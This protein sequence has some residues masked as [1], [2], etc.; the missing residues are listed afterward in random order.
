MEEVHKV[1]HR[2]Y[3]TGFFFGR[4]KDGEFYEYARYLRPWSVAALWIA[5]TNGRGA[6][7][8]EKQLCMRGRA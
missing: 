5:A 2:H 8:A 4:Q 1:S 6:A 7:D 3:G